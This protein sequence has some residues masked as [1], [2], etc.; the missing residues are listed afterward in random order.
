MKYTTHICIFHAGSASMTPSRGCF[1]TPARTLCLVHVQDHDDRYDNRR[2]DGWGGGGG[3]GAWGGGEQAE[4]EAAAVIRP[5]AGLKVGDALTMY[6]AERT[7]LGYNVELVDHNDFQ[8]LLFHA[9]IYGPPPFVGDTIQGF[10]C[11]IRDDGKVRQTPKERERGNYG[12]PVSLTFARLECTTGTAVSAAWPCSGM[13]LATCRKG[14]LRSVTHFAVLGRA[15]T[16][17]CARTLLN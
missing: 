5:P 7:M 11:N 4:G 1:S 16:F 6:V 12:R 2:R 8:A 13:A 9:S 3:G 15:C 17:S 10:V 14:Q